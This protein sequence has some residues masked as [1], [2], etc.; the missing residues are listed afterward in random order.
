MGKTDMN[1]SKEKLEHRLEH[2]REELKV[3]EEIAVKFGSGQ[4]IV[5][6]NGVAIP[7]DEMS[8]L[9]RHYAKHFHE[10]IEI[11]TEQLAK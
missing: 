9:Y 10:L 7:A 5:H 1:I 8:K 11:Y 6:E 2:L 3:C 4:M